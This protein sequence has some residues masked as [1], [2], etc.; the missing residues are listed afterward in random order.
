LTTRQKL[1]PIINITNETDNQVNEDIFYPV[2]ETVVIHENQAEDSIV[3][4][5]I[6]D[7][8]NMAKYN[9]RYRGIDQPTDVIAFPATIS[10][11][12]ILGDIIIDIS[13]AISQKGKKDIDKEL[14]ELFLHGLL[15]LL[16]YDHISQKQQE[17]M[18]SKEEK[19]ILEENKK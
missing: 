19:Y 10:D 3:N 2:L 5:L 11:V 14:E 17:I 16:D 4:L 7:S 6:T 9:K 15:H 8:A 18:R 1:K 12:P 13:T